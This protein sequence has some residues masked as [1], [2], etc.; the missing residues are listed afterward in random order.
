M[1]TFL[2]ICITVGCVTI[3]VGQVAKSAGVAF[4]MYRN[5]LLYGWTIVIVAGVALACWRYFP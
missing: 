1:S 3:V 2:I 5:D 4:S